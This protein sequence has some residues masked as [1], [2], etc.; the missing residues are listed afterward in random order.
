MQANYYDV[1]EALSDLCNRYDVKE[2]DIKLKYNQFRVTAY[3]QDGD[4][5]A[6]AWNDDLLAACND[7]WNS[8][9]AKDEGDPYRMKP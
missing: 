7:V 6:F 3:D 2:L 1:G 8:L 4:A 9:E 5:V